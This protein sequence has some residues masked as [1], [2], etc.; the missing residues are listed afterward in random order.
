MRLRKL[1]FSGIAIGDLYY[2]RDSLR[3]AK[4][5]SE[6]GPTHGGSNCRFTIADCRLTQKEL[7]NQQS[8]ISN[9]QFGLPFGCG[10]RLRCDQPV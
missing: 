1:Y 5:L 9:R 2:F 7:F 4:N 10:Q 8:A 3:L 6:H